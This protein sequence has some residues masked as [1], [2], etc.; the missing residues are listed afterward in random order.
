MQLLHGLAL[1]VVL[2]HQLHVFLTQ[3]GVEG[4]LL[5][6]APLQLQLLFRQP[7]Y[8]LLQALHLQ[9]RKEKKSTAGR[10]GREGGGQMQTFNQAG[11]KVYNNNSTVLITDSLCLHLQ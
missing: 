6:E 9:G 11:R 8:V 7:R 5:A 10:R 1:H 4:G 3:A 2:L